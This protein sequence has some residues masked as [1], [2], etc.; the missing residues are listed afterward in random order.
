MEDETKS[1]ICESDLVRI[2]AAL[3]ALDLQPKTGANSWH[4]MTAE[5]RRNAKRGLRQLLLEQ[6]RATVTPLD[7][8]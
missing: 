7:A 6:R 3:A 4:P 5:A 2:K 8:G 1:R